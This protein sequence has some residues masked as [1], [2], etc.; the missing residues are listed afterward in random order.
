MARVVWNRCASAFSDGTRSPGTSSPAAILP[1][2]GAGG[3][4]GRHSVNGVAVADKLPVVVR[5]GDSMTLEIPGSGGL[6]PAR[7][8]DR[9]AVVRDI[10]DGIVT[11]EA[12]LADY[13]VEVDAEAGG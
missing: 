9:A 12:A 11:S 4:G 3:L 6:G 10:A 2:G 7:E 8:R 1:R 5:T 13:G